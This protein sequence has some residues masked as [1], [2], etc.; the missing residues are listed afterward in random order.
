M[1]LI[2]SVHLAKKA[3]VLAGV[4]GPIRNSGHW[5]IGDVDD[6]SRRDHP[7]S[8]SRPPAC[9]NDEDPSR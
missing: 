1:A 3:E 5:K 9:L 2:E 8:M 7:F 6:R 4:P